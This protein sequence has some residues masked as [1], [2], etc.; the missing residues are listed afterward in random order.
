MD[1]LAKVIS[2]FLSNCCFECVWPGSELIYDMPCGFNPCPLEINSNG[3][4]KR[5]HLEFSSS[6]TKNISPLPQSQWPPNLAGWWLTMRGSHPLNHATP[7]SRG[8]PKSRDKQKSLYLYHQ[9]AYGHQTW[10]DGS[11]PW[12]PATHKVS[13]PFGHVILWHHVTS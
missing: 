10:Q 8:L 6:A 7:W 3:G 11:S 2:T 4:L 13:L 1:G 5:E 9:S 12:W